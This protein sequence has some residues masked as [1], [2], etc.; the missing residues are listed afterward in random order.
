MKILGIV[1][2]ILL[3]ISGIFCLTQPVL[4][5][6]NL[7]WVIGA[8]VLACG[9]CGLV[10]WWQ[11]RKSGESNL[12]DMAGALLTTIVGVLMLCNF[13]AQLFTDMA[14]IM[15]FGVWIVCA[16]VLRIVASVQLKFAWWG[17]GVFWGRGADP[18]R[19]S[20]R[21]C[22]RWCR[23]ISLGWCVAFVFIS[24]GINLVFA[25]ISTKSEDAA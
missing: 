13:W 24:Q 15:L 8:I 1:M 18:G 4:T 3:T 7:S 19:G 12:W 5:F 10:A 14:L 25:A 22:I 11:G 9:I 16:G 23:W 2:G 17:F 6:A 20:M 21:C